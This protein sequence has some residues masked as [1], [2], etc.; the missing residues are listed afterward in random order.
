[1][2][3]RKRR[4]RGG[5]IGMIRKDWGKRIPEKVIE[6]FSVRV[7]KR[8]L[9][10]GICQI[11]S[12]QH[13][14]NFPQYLQFLTYSPFFLTFFQFLSIF[15]AFNLFFSNLTKKFQDFFF[16]FLSD[17]IFFKPLL[18]S[19]FIIVSYKH[20]NGFL[21]QLAVDPLFFLKKENHTGLL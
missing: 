2:I 15:T 20:V 16:L 19:T 12:D 7:D 13:F 1:M 5:G 9:Y 6:W 4:R 8:I 11:T 10:T 17:P 21:Y 14:S 3:W 18:F